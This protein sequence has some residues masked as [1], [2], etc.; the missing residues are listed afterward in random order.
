M[1]QTC[2]IEATVNI[3][4]RFREIIA[5]CALILFTN[6]RAPGPALGQ[7]GDDLSAQLRTEIKTDAAAG[8]AAQPGTEIR[9]DAG[10]TGT[11]ATGIGATGIGTTE[12]GTAETRTTETRTSETRTSETR[13][14]TRSVAA[15]ERIL[16][17]R[18]AEKPEDDHIPD[19][20]AA[21]F[22]R[23][24]NLAK[25]ILTQYGRPD[26]IFAS[27]NSKKSSRPYETALPLSRETGVP[28]DLSFKD[29]DYERLAELLRRDT[30]FAGKLIVVVWH[31][32]NIPD[33]AEALHARDG[34][35]P[36]DWNSKV[37]NQFLQ[38]EYFG[39]S[40]PKVQCLT[41]PF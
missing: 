2:K 39:K 17:M 3:L 1:R 15:P 20:A 19:L 26:Y 5:L 13:T 10:A 27:A 16:L 7:N 29:K 32:G 24:E 18:H 23:A 22:K 28:I 6:L 38:L 35:Y 9:T 11:G 21:G 36:E 12:T 25:Y 41:E 4:K 33:F 31:H 34:D 8:A 30:R 37:Y 14:D 40:R